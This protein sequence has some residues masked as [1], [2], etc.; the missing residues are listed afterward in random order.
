MG[1]GRWRELQVCWRKNDSGERL[2]SSLDDAADLRAKYPSLDIV[3]NLGGRLSHSD[4]HIVLRD[5]IGNPR[6]KVHYYG[7]GRWPGYP[8]GGGSS[9]ELR[10]PNSDNSKAEAWASSDETGKSSWQTYTYRMVANIP[11]GSGTAD[12]VAGFHSRITSG[13]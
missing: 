9:L 1:I 6:T 2:L 12:A 3:G 8:G 13:R 7:D 5:P 4:D 10:D 11:A